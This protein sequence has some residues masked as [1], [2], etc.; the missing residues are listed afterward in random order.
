MCLEAPPTC[1]D[2]AAEETGEGVGK[3]RV[4][5]TAATSLFRL[6]HD[7]FIRVQKH[8]AA[9]AVPLLA[10]L[11]AK[12]PVAHAASPKPPLGPVLSRH[13]EPLAPLGGVV[14]ASGVPAEGGQ[15]RM[16][17]L[18][19]WACMWPQAKPCDANDSLRLLQRGWLSASW[20]GTHVL[21][22]G[23]HPLRHQHAAPSAVEH[24]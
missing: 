13:G 17:C 19:T 11:G 8:L 23:G 3:E 12:R 2:C 5:P 20:S 6:L 21:V 10:A 4:S 15:K 7:G 14:R 24:V 1:C 9:G 18:P 16:K 22:R